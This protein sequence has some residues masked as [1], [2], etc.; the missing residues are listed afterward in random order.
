MPIIAQRQ[1]REQRRGRIAAGIGDQARLRDRLALPFGQSV[2]RRRIGTILRREIDR[3]QPGLRAAAARSRAL[4]RRFRRRSRRRPRRRSAARCRAPRSGTAHRA[5]A[6]NDR[7]GARRRDCGSRGRRPRRRMG[8]QPANRF[9]CRV[10]GRTPHVNARHSCVSQVGELR[11]S[12]ASCRRTSSGAVEPH[13]RFASTEARASS[14]AGERRSSALAR[15]PRKILR[16]ERATLRLRARD[17][18]TDEGVCGARR[19]ALRDQRIGDVGRDRVT[20]ERAGGHLSR[21]NVTASKARANASSVRSAS[22]TIAM[23]WLLVTCRSRWYDGASPQSVASAPAYAPDRRR[24]ASAHELER[25]GI[26]LLRHQ[27]RTGRRRVAEAYVTVCGRRPGDQ[28]LGRCA[29]RRSSRA[30]TRARDR[31]PRRGCRSHRARCATA[32]R[33]RVHRPRAVRS[34]GRLEPASAPLPSG[35]GRAPRRGAPPRSARLR[36]RT[37]RPRRPARKRASPAAPAGGACKP[38]A[39]SPLRARRTRARRSRLQSRCERRAALRA[40]SRT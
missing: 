26:A 14:G 8:V 39:A 9:G 18:G 5:A 28:F 6:E 27:A 11:S 12:E 38:R 37:V 1:E 21:T 10:S 32:Q 17:R 16:V 23:I 24:R 40:R 4:R 15:E 30:R 13:V 20:V 35:A 7:R 29:T 34:S 25:I 2:R 19:H 33:S 22:S 36:A 3:A 31:A